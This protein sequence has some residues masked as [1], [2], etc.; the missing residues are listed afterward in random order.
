M[1]PRVM[2]P[3]VLMEVRRAKRHSTRSTHLGRVVALELLR[4][5]TLSYD[6]EDEDER[7][8]KNPP[9]GR[10][11]CFI[12][13]AIGPDLNVP[14]E[15]RTP[16]QRAHFLLASLDVFLGGTRKRSAKK[17]KSKGHPLRRRGQATKSQ[18]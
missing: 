10:R 18:H 7:H 13:G 2:P 8:E 17:R 11:F 9:P 3:E 15:E 5:L 16:E 14:E 1:T 4:T 6:P 12:G